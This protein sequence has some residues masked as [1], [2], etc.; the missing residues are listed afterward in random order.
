MYINHYTNIFELLRPNV[1][2]NNKINL[3]ADSAFIKNLPK[4]KAKIDYDL[5]EYFYK[6]KIKNSIFDDNELFEQRLILLNQIKQSISTNDF[7]LLSKFSKQLSEILDL[8]RIKEV[9]N[10][11]KNEF[12]Y[13]PATLCFRGRTYFLSSVSFTLYKEFRSCL[14]TDDY[15]ND[16]QVPFHPLNKQINDILVP[17]LPKL[18]LLKNY[19]FFNK[20]VEIQISVCWVLLS[21]AEI[22]KKKL[23]AEVRLERFLDFAIEILNNP[24]DQNFNDLYDDLKFQ[25]L[26]KILDEV[27]NDIYVQRLISKDATASCFQHLIKIL[28]K[29]SNESLQ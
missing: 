15:E 22:N 10:F 18:S 16:Y 24:L 6:K 3:S 5:L 8:I 27:E 4:L 21:V 7:D 28:G 2:S 19:S 1:Y 29:N 11:K 17:H 25:S 23:G 9:L 12:F 13:F 20:P 14:Y 26:K